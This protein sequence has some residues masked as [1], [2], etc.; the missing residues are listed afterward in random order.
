[1]KW[2]TISS[3]TPTILRT[4]ETARTTIRTRIRI[5]T[6][7]TTIRTRTTTRIRITRTTISKALI[8]VGTPVGV[9]IYIS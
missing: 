8:A 4:A 2:T 5:R 9:P 1:M 3:T 7:R 6:T